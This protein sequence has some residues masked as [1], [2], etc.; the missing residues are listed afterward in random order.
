MGDVVY[1]GAAMYQ[2]TLDLGLPV[3]FDRDGTLLGIALRTEGDWRWYVAYEVVDLD[4]FDFTPVGG[5]P[6]AG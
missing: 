1:V 5:T 2:D 3:T 6:D 4:N